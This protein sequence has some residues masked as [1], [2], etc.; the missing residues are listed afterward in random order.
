MKLFHFSFSSR[1]EESDNL[2]EVCLF[3]DENLEKDKEDLFYQDEV[4]R[5][6]VMVVSCKHY[7][8][9]EKKS[10]WAGLGLKIEKNTVL[11]NINI[12]LIITTN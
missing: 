8:L 6:M 4:M 12:L 11:L 1:D 5:L 7:P 2:F 10:Y 9:H 3:Q